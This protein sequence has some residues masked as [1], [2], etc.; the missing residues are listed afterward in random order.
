MPVKQRIGGRHGI[1][2]PLQAGG[3][4]RASGSCLGHVVGG[5]GVQAALPIAAT[6]AAKSSFSMVMPS[7]SV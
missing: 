1:P 2:Y 7:P 6:S 3:E 5:D 4:I